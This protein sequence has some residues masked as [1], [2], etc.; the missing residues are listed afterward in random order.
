M[1]IG[2]EK[3]NNIDNSDETN[4]Q[5]FNDKSKDLDTCLNNT[6]KNEENDRL[7]RIND[8]KKRIENNTYKIDSTDL[9]KKIIE[10][11]KGGALIES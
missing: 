8:I 3:F 7:Q 6:D 5:K 4:K 10:H 11:S 1:N 9:A 2:S